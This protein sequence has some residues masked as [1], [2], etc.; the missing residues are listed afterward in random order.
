[1]NEDRAVSSQLEDREAMNS[2]QQTV[3]LSDGHFIPVL[4]F[5]TYAPQEVMITVG[6]EGCNGGLR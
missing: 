3:R 5:G 1:M 4:G 2:K 6:L